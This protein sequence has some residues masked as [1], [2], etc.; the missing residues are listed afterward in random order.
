MY[1]VILRKYFLRGRLMPLNL[2]LWFANCNFLYGYLIIHMGEFR[3]SDCCGRSIY[4]LLPCKLFANEKIPAGGEEILL[5][6]KKFY[7]VVDDHS[8]RR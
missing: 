4:I 5:A 7:L 6:D 1:C 3:G 2:I 8:T